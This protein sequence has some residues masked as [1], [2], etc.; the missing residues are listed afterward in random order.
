MAFT[1]VCAVSDIPED[2]GLRIEAGPRP[3]AVFKADDGFFAIED[4]CP[5]GDWPLSEGYFDGRLVECSLH[6][7]KFCVRTGKVCAPPAVRDL[8]VFPVRV[9]GERVLIDLR[10]ESD[11]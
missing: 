8:N 6:M 10:V 9:E 7:A 11:T 2:A 4:K 5:H 1:D 3:I